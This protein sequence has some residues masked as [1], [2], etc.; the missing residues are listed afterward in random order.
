MT[1]VDEKSKKSVKPTKSVKDI[2]ERTELFKQVAI[3]VLSSR[4]ALAIKGS[5]DGAI[6][7]SDFLFDVALLTEGILNAAKKF[8]EV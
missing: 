2:Q 4:H 3:A 7:S 5:T 8:G 1:N 6:V